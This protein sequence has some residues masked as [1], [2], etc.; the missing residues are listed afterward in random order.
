MR[1]SL[2]DHDRKLVTQFET[3]KFADFKSYLQENYVA[4]VK[5][6][7]KSPQLWSDEIPYL[8]K[9][10]LEMIDLTEMSLTS[11]VQMSASAK[12]ASITPEY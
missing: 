3:P 8:Y 9:L 5:Q 10:V 6:T 2:Y 7:I 1:L 12:S 4:K 11:R